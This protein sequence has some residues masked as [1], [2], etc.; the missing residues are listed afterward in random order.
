M[1][2]TIISQYHIFTIKMSEAKIIDG[3]RGSKNLVIKD[4]I[5]RRSRINKNSTI[6]WRCMRSK[7]SSM[8]LT[9]SEGCIIKHN[10]NHS[11]ETKEGKGAATLITERMRKR[12]REEL[13]PIP[14]IYEEERQQLLHTTTAAASHLK[15]YHEVKSQLY[16]S[17]RKLVPSNPNSAA[18]LMLEGEWRNTN[19]GDEFVLVDEV[20]DNRRII[21][22]GTKS[23]LKR[24]CESLIIHIDGTLRCAQKFSFNFISFI[25]TFKS[26]EHYQNYFVFCQTKKHQL[27]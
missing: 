4:A 27:T 26:T 22:F 17:R 6:S 1:F 14:K 11:H 8:V 21:V 3:Q 7:C 19:E 5:Y 24:L 15:L 10:D 9:T 12:A 25:Q 18:E 13:T 16:R 20:I 2:T 23:N